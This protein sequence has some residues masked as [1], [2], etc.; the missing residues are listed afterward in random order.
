MTIA[1]LIAKLRAVDQDA[2]ALFE[3]GTL[4]GI[5]EVTDIEERPLSRCGWG[6]DDTRQ[7]VIFSEASEKEAKS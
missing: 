5:Y 2:I 3:D 1:E 4:G 7:A 6:P